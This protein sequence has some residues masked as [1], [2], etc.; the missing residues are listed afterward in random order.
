MALTPGRARGGFFFRGCERA[1]EGD[2]SFGGLV[3]EVK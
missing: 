2:S 1:S 3:G